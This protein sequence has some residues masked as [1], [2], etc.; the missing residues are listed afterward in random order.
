MDLTAAEYVVY[1]ATYFEVKLCLSDRNQWHIS[2]DKWP[3]PR[4]PAR[5]VCDDTYLNNVPILTEYVSARNDQRVFK[6]QG[7]HWTMS[8]K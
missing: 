5:L 3:W 6:Y 8:T 2:L 4:W 1:L 7:F